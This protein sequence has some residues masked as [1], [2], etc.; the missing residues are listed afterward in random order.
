MTVC[1]VRIQLPAQND[2]STD[3]FVRRSAAISPCQNYRYSLIRA[4][5]DQRPPL[6][7]GMLNPSTADHSVDDP[8]ITRCMVRAQDGGFGALIIWNLFAFRSTNPKALVTALDPIGP[9]NDKWIE[10][11]IQHCISNGGT[12]FVGWGAIKHFQ[13]RIDH[14]EAIITK[15]PIEAKYLGINKCGNPKHPLYVS[16]KTEFRNYQKATS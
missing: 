15:F 13:D 5:D 16:Y 7:A 14:V 6:V 2:T 9:E 4:W 8:T 3:L 11:S 10:A 1:E 12:L